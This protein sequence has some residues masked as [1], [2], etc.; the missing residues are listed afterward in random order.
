MNVLNVV[1]VNVLVVIGYILVMAARMLVGY[2][3]H[4]WDD[5]RVI[6]SRHWLYERR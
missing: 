6:E 1:L 3:L 5:E 2:V 4:D